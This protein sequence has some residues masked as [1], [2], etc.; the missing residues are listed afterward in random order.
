MALGPVTLDAVNRLINRIGE[1]AGFD[2]VA[3]AHV[4]HDDCGSVAKP[5]MI[6]VRRRLSRERNA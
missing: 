5:S 1:R 6:V 2:F 3:H 4:L